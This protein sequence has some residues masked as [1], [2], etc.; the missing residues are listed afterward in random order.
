MLPIWAKFHPTRN[1]VSKREYQRHHTL[2]L[3]NMKKYS[4]MFCTKYTKSAPFQLKE[5]HQ[6]VILLGTINIQIINSVTSSIKQWYLQ[7]LNQ[8]T[9]KVHSSLVFYS[10][11]IDIW[12]RKLVGQPMYWELWNTQLTTPEK[13]LHKTFVNRHQKYLARKNRA[14]D[15][16]S[17]LISC[18]TGE[19]SSLSNLK[20]YVFMESKI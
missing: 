9:V 2:E 5:N 6:C 7:D 10:Y 13:Y 8:P 16:T 20:K 4:W 3:C 15:T 14:E 19:C 18:N 17:F 12:S 11:I 1:Y